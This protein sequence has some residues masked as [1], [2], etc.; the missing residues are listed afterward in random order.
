[1][2]KNNSEKE[3][4]KAGTVSLVLKGAGSYMRINYPFLRLLQISLSMISK[5]ARLQTAQLLQTEIFRLIILTR[6]L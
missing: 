4:K 6:Y 5:S 3:N 2:K 1:M